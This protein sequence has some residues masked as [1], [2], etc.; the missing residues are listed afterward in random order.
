MSIFQD[1]TLTWNGESKTIPSD[2]V[3]GLIAEVE[4]CITIDDLAKGKPKL[5]KIAMAYCAA[6]KYAGF[7]ARTD[8]TYQQMLKGESQAAALVTGLIEIMIPPE[9]I[10][11][12]TK[13]TR[14]QPSKTRK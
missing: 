2:R 1:I 9:T 7:K 8:E 4:E 13:K 11:P 5:A 3:L 10:Q 12:K 14:R 6:L